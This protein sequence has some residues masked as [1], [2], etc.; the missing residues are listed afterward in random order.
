[1]NMSTTDITPQQTAPGKAA[2]PPKAKPV[3]FSP[4]KPALER[5]HFLRLYQVFCNLSGLE[6]QV[7]A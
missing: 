2:A 5:S 6:Y 4:P 1:M 3:P 7:R